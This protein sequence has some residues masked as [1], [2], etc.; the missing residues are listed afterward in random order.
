VFTTEEMAA[1]G[2][3]DSADLS[4]VNTGDRA[5]DRLRGATAARDAVR[6][7]S[8]RD[9]CTAPSRGALLDVLP[10]FLGP[11]DGER[12]RVEP[13]AHDEF[14]LPQNLR[15]PAHDSP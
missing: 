9:S 14:A 3:P 6:T 13:P 2:L 12:P 4:N 10:F 1:P 7:S 5:Q 8:P 11:M 15:F